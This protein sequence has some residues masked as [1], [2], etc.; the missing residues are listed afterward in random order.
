[1][2]SPQSLFSVVM[3]NQKHS[4]IADQDIERQVLGLE[5]L[6]K[7]HHGSAHTMAC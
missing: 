6:S 2:N 4:S 7:G 5:S 3:G 1:M